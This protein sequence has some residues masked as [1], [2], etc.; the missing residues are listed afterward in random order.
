MTGVVV[1][2]CVR[3]NT[4]EPRYDYVTEELPALVKAQF[5]VTEAQVR[6]TPLAVPHTCLPRS[7]SA[8]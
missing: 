1:V 4:C 6:A 2:W 3:V 7:T 8:T 5:P